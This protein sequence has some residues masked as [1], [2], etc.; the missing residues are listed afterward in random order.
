MIFKIIIIYNQESKKKHITI[1]GLKVERNIDEIEEKSGMIKEFIL[2]YYDDLPEESKSKVKSKMKLFFD[3][4]ES[5][6][7]LYNFLEEEELLNEVFG[8]NR[9]PSRGVLKL[10]EDDLKDCIENRVL[11]IS[12]DNTDTD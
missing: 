6:G 1:G 3:G 7:S 2:F 4:S 9:D 10:I 5:I 8:A 12:K 11:E